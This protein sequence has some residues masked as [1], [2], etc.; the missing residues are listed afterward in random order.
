MSSAPDWLYLYLL[1]LLPTVLTI[2][3]WFIIA[4]QEKDKRRLDR[5]DRRIDA[6]LTLLNQIEA[7]ALQYYKVDDKDNILATGIKQNLKWLSKLCSRIDANLGN[8]V[9]DLRTVTTGGNFESKQRMPLPPTDTKFI[10]IRDAV[11]RLQDRL[12]SCHDY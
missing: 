12:E 5:K 2:A 1:P 4:R 8:L 6:A 9:T 10:E 7:D 11:F 3:G